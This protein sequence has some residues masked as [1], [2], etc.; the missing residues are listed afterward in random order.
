MIIIDS[1]ILIW[2]LRGNEEYKKKFISAVETANGQLFITPIQYM[3]IICGVREKELVSTELFLDS[4]KMINID[5]ET[6]KLAGYFLG[7]FMKSHSIHNADALIAAV[8]KIHDCKIW[9]N[10]CKHYP[11]LNANEFFE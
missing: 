3:E 4:L 8:V 9:T 5:K 2:I 1:D 6:G 11:M 10:N 7:K